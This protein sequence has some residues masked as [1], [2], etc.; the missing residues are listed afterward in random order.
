MEK[1]IEKNIEILYFFH[2]LKVV[3]L[4]CAAITKI[5][6]CIERAYSRFYY[7]RRITLVI[8]GR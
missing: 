4:C 1:L 2:V 8:L 7:R 6:Q 3:E 5:T